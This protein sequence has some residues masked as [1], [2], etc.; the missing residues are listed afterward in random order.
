M[1]K[2]A[3]YIIFILVVI[4]AIF[5]FFHDRF[6]AKDRNIKYGNP[7]MEKII[8]ECRYY[9]Q[10][11]EVQTL[12]LYEGRN[13]A[14]GT[15][16]YSLTYEGEGIKETQIFISAGDFTVDSLGFTEKEI[17]LLCGRGCITIP[18][19]K[20][21]SKI[22]VPLIYYNGKEMKEGSFLSDKI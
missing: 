9:K 8:K 22:E 4:L 2:Y 12:K 13:S 21:E 11:G 14:R 1:K 6:K 17:K 7:Q 19:D 16:W 15:S 5:A 20:L 18:V 10:N 3:S